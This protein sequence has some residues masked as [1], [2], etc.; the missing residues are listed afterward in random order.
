M[1]QG[2]PGRRRSHSPPLARR[3]SAPHD[4][5]VPS[6]GVPLYRDDYREEFPNT[7]AYRPD[8]DAWRPVTDKPGYYA[9]T[10]SPPRYDRSEPETWAADGRNSAVNPSWESPSAW[11]RPVVSPPQATRVVRD[12][13]FEPSASWK[14]THDDRSTQCVCPTL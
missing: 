9:R 10:P 8:P 12:T 4:S 5:Y 13:L 3:A 11:S 6:R 14:K 7:S 2:P 1:A